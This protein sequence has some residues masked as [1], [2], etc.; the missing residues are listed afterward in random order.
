MSDQQSILKARELDL[1]K[2]LALQKT[3]CQS[4]HP[5]DPCV[6]GLVQMPPTL[7]QGHA[8]RIYVKSVLTWGC[9]TS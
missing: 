6:P 5:P 8:S 3:R 1:D 7:Q 2:Q 9:E 4:K